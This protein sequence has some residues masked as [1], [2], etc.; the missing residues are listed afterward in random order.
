MSCA[1]QFW[2]SEVYRESLDLQT[3][4][5]QLHIP[6]NL[7]TNVDSTQNF[8][9]SDINE[10]LVSPTQFPWKS[11]LCP[12]WS[13]LCLFSCCYS[14]FLPSHAIIS[15]P[16]KQAQSIQNCDTVCRMVSTVIQNCWQSNPTL[17][18]VFGRQTFIATAADQH[19]STASYFTISC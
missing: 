11:S 12:C 17:L 14:T 7:Y 2:L 10:F 15:P 6:S 4:T 9:V 8:T 5:H 18:E 16:W 3:P 19:A 1:P 13:Q